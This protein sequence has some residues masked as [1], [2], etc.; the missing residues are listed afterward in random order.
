MT[1]P[2][3]AAIAPQVATTQRATFLSLLSF[4]G[5]ISFFGL[6]IVLSVSI[7][8][9]GLEKFSALSGAL[10]LSAVI[11]AV[12]FTALAATS[13]TIQHVDPFKDD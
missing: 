7:D 3:N 2:L 9:L 10:F 13:R 5:R 8:Q 4:T 6:L 1:A 12:G 11:G